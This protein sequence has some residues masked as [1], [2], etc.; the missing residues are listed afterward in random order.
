MD[1]PVAEAPAHV[2]DLDDLAAELLGH[3]IDPGWAVPAVA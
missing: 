3:G 1:A 2:R